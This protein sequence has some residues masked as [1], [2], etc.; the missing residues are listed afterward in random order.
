M[1][2]DGDERDYFGKSVVLSDDGATALVGAPYDENA[3]GT[4]AGS[5]YVFSQTDGA[6]SQRAKLT[7]DAG[8]E[9]DHF[10]WSTGLSM[11]GTTALVSTL[12]DADSNG[13]DTG[14]A[15][16]YNE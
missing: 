12:D 8:D 16:V 13:G 5:A 2:N 7:P 6:W 1:P 10:G 4:R 11:D 15:Y 3:N 9:R 14:S